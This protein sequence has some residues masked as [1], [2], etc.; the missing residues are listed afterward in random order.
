M[1][2]GTALYTEYKGDKH[3]AFWHFDKDIALATEQYYARSL[4]RKYNI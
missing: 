2:N 4:E 3:D 1:Q